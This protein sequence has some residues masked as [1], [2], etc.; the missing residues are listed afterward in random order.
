MS[1]NH[2]SEI[3]IARFLIGRISDGE[4]RHIDEH[5]RACDRCRKEIDG[6]EAA[7]HHFE[8]QVFPRTLPAIERRSARP[9]GWIMALSLASMAS[10]VVILLASPKVRTPLPPEA[11]VYGVKGSGTLRLFAR[12]EGRVFPVDA[13]TVLRPGDQVRFA[14]QS[15]GARYALIASIDGRGQ[16][17][18]YFAS[19]QLGDD[20]GPGWQLVGES[21]ALD[22]SAGPER[23]FAIFS[24]ERL[25]DEVVLP[26]LRQ[27]TTGGAEA[28]RN[29]KELPLPF[30]QASVLFEKSIGEHP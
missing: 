13:A 9:R 8:R 21:I 14:V 29:R 26:A 10:A 1:E 7:R 2:P 5:V 4:A 28:L 3:L 19:T 24:N 17:S 27:A 6:A 20:A 18:I 23:I 11:P 30:P 25:D 15:S 12:R 16:A 22:D